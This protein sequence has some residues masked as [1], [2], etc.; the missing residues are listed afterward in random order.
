MSDL[1]IRKGKTYAHVLRYSAEPVV[2]KP[3]TSISKSA[4][5]TVGAAGHGLVDGWPT[6]IVSVIGMDDVFASDTPKPKDYHQPTVIDADTVEFNRLNSANLKAYKSGGYLQYYT[7][8]DLTGM[9]PRMVV[10][11]KPG[12]TIIASSDA[13]HVTAGAAELELDVDLALKKIAFTFTD[14]VTAAIVPSKAVFEAEIT[15]SMGA[16]HYLDSGTITFISE[17]AT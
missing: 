13:A 10:W 3:I 16:T 4:P 1:E 8:V 11:D 9:T 14:E 12:G 2:Y 17:L 7:P 6:A 15:D 5:M